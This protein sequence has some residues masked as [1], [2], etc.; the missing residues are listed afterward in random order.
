ML[1]RETQGSFPLNARVQCQKEK[2]ER[3]YLCHLILFMR[4]LLTRDL[5]NL[6]YQPRRTKRRS[7]NMSV[8]LQNV[9]FHIPLHAVLRF[10]QEC[11]DSDELEKTIEMSPIG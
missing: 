3:K 1:T 11:L 2:L 9:A 10:F 6:L 8:M 7:D 4:M 5:S